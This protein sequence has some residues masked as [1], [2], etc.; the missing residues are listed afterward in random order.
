MVH[1]LNIRT[2]I[3]KVP[4]VR[5][6]DGL[7]ISSRN[8]YLSKPERDSATIIYKSLSLARKLHSQGIKK[9]G[10]IKNSM[11]ELINSVPFTKVDYISIAKPHNLKELDFIG[12]DALISVAVVI[13]KTRLI[14]NIF[15]K[16]TD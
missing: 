13:G 6:T 1:D 3:L 9:T 5:E 10:F 14:D 2:K 4:T 12:C 11:A 15:L 16:S 7:A 8:M